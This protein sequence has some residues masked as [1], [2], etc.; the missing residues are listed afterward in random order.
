MRL[1]KIDLRLAIAELPK[2]RLRRVQPKTLADRFDQFRVGGARKN[3]CLPHVDGRRGG[4]NFVLTQIRK[5][6]INIG[7]SLCINLACDV[8]K[9]VT[10]HATLSRALK[11]R[12]KTTIDQSSQTSG[13]NN[14]CVIIH[15]I[16][17]S[18]LL[19]QCREPTFVRAPSSS[20]H[21]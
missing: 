19:C 14:D 9:L 2:L 8:R 21:W 6:S 5:E 10:A 11:C 15:L 3:L 4:R 16:V 1:T 20:S 12:N 17:H 13:R 18:S 7:A